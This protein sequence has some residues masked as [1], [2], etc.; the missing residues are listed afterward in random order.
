MFCPRCGIE[1]TP[2]Q[3]FCNK[4]GLQ[5]GGVALALEGRV[6]A[7]I[8]EIDKAARRLNGT[9]KALGIFF[10]IVLVGLLLK[11][12]LGVFSFLGS[13]TLGIV[14]ALPFVI[15][16]LQRMRRAKRL[17]NRQA[18]PEGPAI[19]QSE[20]PDVQLPPAPINDPNIVTPD[21]QGSVMEHTTHKLKRPDRS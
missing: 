12:Q 20:R 6:D 4:C 3:K 5:L 8:T 21:I 18:A 19:D 17:L 16:I 13:A 9:L 14:V 1:N 11:G 2:E 15:M 7:A 10:L